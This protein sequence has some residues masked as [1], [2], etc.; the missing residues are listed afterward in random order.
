LIEK[1]SALLRSNPDWEEAGEVGDKR[2]RSAGAVPAAAKSATSL[3]KNVFR[4]EG[5]VTGRQRI[6]K[7]LR[8][9]GSSEWNVNQ[10]FP[11]SSKKAQDIS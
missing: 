10:K 1:G 11:I 2:A 3:P 9:E 6:G 8:I 4:E 7:E 5:L